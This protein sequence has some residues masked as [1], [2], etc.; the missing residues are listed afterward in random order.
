[1]G[2][3]S[4]PPSR[5]FDIKDYHETVTEVSNSAQELTTLVNSINQLVTTVGLD[6]LLPKIVAAI[7]HA[8]DEGRKIIDHSFRQAVLLII[9]WMVAYVVARA[10]VNHITKRRARTAVG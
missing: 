3:P 4:D 7:D 2:G 10:I 5:P 8:E 9:I 6:Q 1:M